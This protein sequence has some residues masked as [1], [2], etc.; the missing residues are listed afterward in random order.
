PASFELVAGAR[1]CG[2]KHRRSRRRCSTGEACGP[3]QQETA[4]RGADLG[5]RRKRGR[6]CGM[7]LPLHGFRSGFVMKNIARHLPRGFC[8][9]W[10][11]AR[12][13][14]VIVPDV[15]PHWPNPRRL[16]LGGGELVSSGVELP[17]CKHVRE[18]ET[19]LR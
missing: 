15:R 6:E 11:R 18:C 17:M 7:P 10:P 9:Q 2:R 4:P 5:R 8:M 3:A 12:T 16:P 13:G 19:F 14:R 1:R